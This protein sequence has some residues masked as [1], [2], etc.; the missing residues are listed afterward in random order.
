[1][2]IYMVCDDWT[3]EA[4]YYEDF[5]EAMA[6][7]KE[8]FDEFWKNQSGWHNG[9]VGIQDFYVEAVQLITRK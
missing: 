7:Q 6:R 9:Q 4:E 8:R 3:G 1:M 5:D 2:T